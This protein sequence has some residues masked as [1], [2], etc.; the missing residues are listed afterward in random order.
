MCSDPCVWCQCRSPCCRS[1]WACGN[2]ND[3]W[4]CFCHKLDPRFCPA[5]NRDSRSEWSLKE[6]FPR[7]TSPS[8]SSKLHT[9]NASLN[10]RRKFINE[11]VCRSRNF[12]FSFITSLSKI[13]YS[14]AARATFKK[15]FPRPH[16]LSYFFSF[17]CNFCL[18]VLLLHFLFCRRPSSFPL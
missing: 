16:K 13:V 12:L 18:L 6:N 10:R 3:R 14:H 1:P 8:I 15:P 2:R 11:C 4:C 7:Q 9:R 17:F 5:N